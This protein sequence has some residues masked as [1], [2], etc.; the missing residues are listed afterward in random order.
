[1]GREAN[2]QE[3][4]KVRSKDER[5]ILYIQELPDRR[6]PKSA[7]ERRRGVRIKWARCDVRVLRHC[8]RR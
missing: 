7:K 6:K 3:E 2:G 4:E 1:M 5:A 8:V